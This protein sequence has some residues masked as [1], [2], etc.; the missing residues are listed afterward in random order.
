[1]FLGYFGGRDWQGGRVEGG[2]P[3]DQR[4]LAGKYVRG[5]S[6]C[7]SYCR[8]PIRN[9]RANPNSALLHHPSFAPTNAIDTGLP[10][11]IPST[12]SGLFKWLSSVTHSSHP[13]SFSPTGP[14]A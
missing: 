14:R 12:A 6:S 5:D 11:V 4:S 9:T 2:K 10:D 3:T 1:M 13:C 8:L 7:Q